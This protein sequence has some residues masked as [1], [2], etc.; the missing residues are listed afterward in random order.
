MTEKEVKKSGPTI[1]VCA[2]V[3]TEEKRIEEF[4]TSLYDFADEII[5]S[6]TGSKDR[7]V[8]IVKDFMQKGYTKI[9]LHQYRSPEPL[10]HIGKAK[11]FAISKATKEYALV[12]DADERLSGGFKRDL[13]AF[14]REHSPEV[15]R[16]MRH[17][18]LLTALVEPIERIIKNGR[19]I[20]YGTDAEAL[21]HEYFIHHASVAT[22]LPPLWH[23]QREKHWLLRPDSRFLYLSIEI[24]KTPKVKS[25]FG[26][27]LRGFWMFQY[28]FR[29]VYFRQKLFRQGMIGFR[30][31]VLRAFYALLIQI[32]VG[33]KR[34]EHQ[35]WTSQEY[36]D[37]I[38]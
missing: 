3:N 37:S 6:D 1:S 36:R 15:V 24:E 20:F 32:F 12:L 11:N 22:F 2:S 7:T 9:S 35:Y 8:E 38:K 16:I 13:K 25:F 17:D 10:F 23:C 21:T 29:R 4:I 31:A 19:G 30:Y 18:D 33:L 5:I 14:L 26:H 28:K 27:L 34:D